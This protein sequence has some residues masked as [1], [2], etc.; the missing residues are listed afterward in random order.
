MTAVVLPALPKLELA[1]QA[2]PK[3]EQD[4]NGVRLQR[5]ALIEPAGRD[6]YRLSSDFSR[7][8]S[9]GNLNTTPRAR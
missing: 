4:P 6:V 9:L 8:G 5:V 2:P 3:L 7:V 1:T